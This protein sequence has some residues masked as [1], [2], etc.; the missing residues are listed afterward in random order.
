M[1]IYRASP[2]GRRACHSSIFLFL[3]Q[4][5][6]LIYLDYVF[7]S[8][9]I[10]PTSLPTNSIFFS[11]CPP[12]R[13]KQTT[14]KNQLNRLNNKTKI[15]N[16][17]HPQ[18]THRDCSVL[19][20]HSR[21]RVCL[22]GWSIYLV[23]RPF[24]NTDFLFAS[25]RYLR[26]P[27]W[28]GLGLF[29]HFLCSPLG[30]SLLWACTGFVSATFVLFLW[31]SPAVSGRLLFPGSHPSPLALNGFPFPFPLPPPPLR[32]LDPEGGKEFDKRHPIYGWV[33]F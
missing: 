2:S 26:V 18:K 4:F 9:K 19:A 3:I 23:A 31:I 10:L 32:S 16:K 22:G 13:N 21:H 17:K 8:P 6:S 12:K 7:S 14:S 11:L 24:E 30:L 5:F 1:V 25:R 27:S 15:Q 20:I 28:L 29:I 33:L